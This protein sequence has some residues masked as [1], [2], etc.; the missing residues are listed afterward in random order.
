MLRPRFLAIALALVGAPA[1]A[2]DKKGP[3]GSPQLYRELIDCKLLTEPA[4]RL[5]CFDQR[6][7]ALEAATAKKEI[8]IADRE[9]VRQARRGL[10]GFA[11]PI[12]K[13]FGF[14][15]QS[16]DDEEAIKRLETTVAAVSSRNGNLVLRFAEAGT[17]EQT[18][19][20]GFP[21]RPKVGN[22]AVISRGALG[23]YFV[24]VDGMAGIKMRRV[25]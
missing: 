17:W 1:L 5:A 4:A 19:R 18:D 15:G 25:E 14:G 24:S 3:E 12:G 10:F 8:M 7:A 22:K 16:E 11:A 9:Q 21:L 13:L 2:D 6:V 20:F 23:A